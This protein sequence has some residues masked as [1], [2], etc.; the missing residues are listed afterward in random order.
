MSDKQMNND[1]MIRT[2]ETAADM[3]GLLAESIEDGTGAIYACV[4]CFLQA[5]DE[6]GID[7]IAAQKLYTETIKARKELRELIEINQE[8][9][10]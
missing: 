3:E 7:V 9:L 10:S 6:A 5:F 4:M 8:V 2:V 1:L